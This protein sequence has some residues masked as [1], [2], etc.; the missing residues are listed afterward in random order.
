MFHYLMYAFSKK[1]YGAN[2]GAVPSHDSSPYS[3]ICSVI[4][5]LWKLRLFHNVFCL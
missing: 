4:I 2:D 3:D 1:K 5:T